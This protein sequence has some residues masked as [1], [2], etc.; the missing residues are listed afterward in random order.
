[1]IGISKGFKKMK[2]DN[3][4]KG[5]ART[6]HRGLLMA[7]GVSKKKYESAFHMYSKLFF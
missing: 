1:M 2:S 6:P 3:I 5:I 7:T 4:K